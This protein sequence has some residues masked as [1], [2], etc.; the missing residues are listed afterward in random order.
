M[1]GW[2][3]G[4]W[5][6]KMDIIRDLQS[7][8][9]A[10]LWGLITAL[11]TWSRDPWRWSEF[12]RCPW[13]WL[14]CAEHPAESGCSWAGRSCPGRSGSW[15]TQ[16]MASNL[17]QTHD[18]MVWVYFRKPGTYKRGFFFCLSERGSRQIL[19]LPKEK[20]MQSNMTFFFPNTSR[21][22]LPLTVS[23]WY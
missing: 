5:D 10:S 19:L 18:R 16:N 22:G 17:I 6:K 13:S 1:S 8:A 15:Q 11:L 14:V 12:P 4:V 23:E 3:T 7:T 2:Y 9:E 20:W 21:E